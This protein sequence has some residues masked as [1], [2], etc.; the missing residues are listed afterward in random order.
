MMPI[1]VLVMILALAIA[2]PTSA[3]AQGGSP[4]GPPSKER[5]M[6]RE[7]PP[8]AKALVEKQQGEMRDLRQKYMEE[9]RAL[10]EKHR[11]ERQALMQKLRQ[12][13]KLPGPSQEKKTP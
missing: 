11:E 13:G 3:W 4:P 12:E 10:R 7:L 1:R 2:L 8:E 9:M 6:K 5:P